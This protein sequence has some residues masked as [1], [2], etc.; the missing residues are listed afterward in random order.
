MEAIGASPRPGMG[1]SNGLA[2]EI[3]GKALR[4]AGA[5]WED[6]VKLTLYVVDVSELPT[7]R[8]VRDEFVDT[9]RPA[10]ELARPRSPASSTRRAD[11]GRSVA[12]KLAVRLV[13]CTFPSSRGGN[14]ATAEVTAAAMV[15][16]ARR[17]VTSGWCQGAHARDGAGLRFPRGRGGPFVV[18][19]GGATHEVGTPRTRGTTLTSSPTWP[20]RTPSR[21][22][23]DYSGEVS[24]GVAKRWNDA[25][26]RTQ[27]DVV[28]LWTARWSRVN[29]SSS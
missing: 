22:H 11:R 1:T 5:G 10:D 25:A 13:V 7:I 12:W 28:E 6:V 3:V 23:T 9:A 2:F 4:A 29:G 16:E 27:A 24:D 26:K 15:S 21:S 20:T 18:P 17:L 8:A 14:A 19:P